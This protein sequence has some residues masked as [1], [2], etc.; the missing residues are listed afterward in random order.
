MMRRVNVCIDCLVAVLIGLLLAWAAAY[1]YSD[2]RGEV[3]APS[4]AGAAV[5]Q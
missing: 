4:V 2:E 5:C 3:R 1:G